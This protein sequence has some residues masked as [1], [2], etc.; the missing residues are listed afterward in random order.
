MQAW[1]DGTM[2]PLK[3]I[4]D[5]DIRK[6]IN[7]LV[8]TVKGF[9]EIASIQTPRYCFVVE[10]FDIT[11]QN[12]A[13]KTKVNYTPVGF[14]RPFKNLAS[15][16]NDETIC[17]KFKPDHARMIIGIDTLEKTL[18]F[19]NQAQTE[20]YLNFIKACMARLKDPA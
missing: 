12:L 8:D 19:N 3:M 14:Y 4:D 17:R 1:F 5:M 13:M 18:D 6:L 15:E 11:Y 9:L 2:F 7:S 20:V 10:K 16:L